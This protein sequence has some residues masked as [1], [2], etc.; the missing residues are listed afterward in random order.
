MGLS[1]LGPA[2]TSSAATIIHLHQ[3]REMRDGAI[4]YDK[5]PTSSFT[6]MHQD[7]PNHRWISQQ[8]DMDS[9]YRRDLATKANGVSAHHQE[10][11]ARDGGGGSGYESNGRPI[12]YNNQQKSMLKPRSLDRSQYTQR[13]R[14]SSPLGGGQGGLHQRS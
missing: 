5:K 4:I 3:P 7:K 13:R 1:K 9:D 2:S 6:F 14:E 10:A 8:S 12:K 11:R